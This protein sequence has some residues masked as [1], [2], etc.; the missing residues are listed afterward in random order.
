MKHS[1]DYTAVGKYVMSIFFGKLI[2]TFCHPP[3]SLV[4]FVPVDFLIS[5]NNN[6]T[7]MT[8]SYSNLNHH[9]RS[10]SLSLEEY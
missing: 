4:S 9:M 3:D 6:E 5:I 10:S 8:T 1:I 2:Y 7:Y